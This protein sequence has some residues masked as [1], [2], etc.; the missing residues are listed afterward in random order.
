MVM[1]HSFVYAIMFGDDGGIRLGC[2][3]KHC[4]VNAVSDTESMVESALYAY[5]VLEH[6]DLE[7]ETNGVEGAEKAYTI[8]HDSLSVLV[9]DVD[10]MDIEQSEENTRAHADVLQEVLEYDGGR[11]V[12]PMGFG[13]VFKDAR[14][15]NNLVR[16]ARPVFRRTLNEIDGM[17]ELGL[18]VVA[19]ADAEVDAEA[20]E[21]EVTRRFD[22]LAAETTENDQFSDRLIV[23]RSFLV[24]RD[25]RDAFDRAVGQFEE[26][27]DDLLV[28]YSG[29][30]PPY[31]FVDI[32]IGAKR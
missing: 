23:N 16:E 28:Q 8:D 30:W 31:N 18:K 10:T 11:T 12:I 19:D 2:I 20:I 5:G 27:H 6:E 9:S 26:E 1:K 7:L 3:F 25:D 22:D 24:D 17:Y 13:M 21:E 15:L 29:P 14:T 32:Q 4:I